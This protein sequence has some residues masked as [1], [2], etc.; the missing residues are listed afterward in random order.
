MRRVALIVAAAALVAA[1]VGASTA[2]ASTF[3]QKGISDDAQ[4]LYGDPDKVFPNL[5]KLHTQVI[6]VNLWW[7]GPNGVARRRPVNACEP[8]RSGLSLGHVRPHGSVRACLQDDAD[9]HRDRDAIVGERLRRLERRADEAV[10]SAG[11]RDRRGEALLGHLQDRRR[12]ADR[13]G[14]EVDRLERAE[15]PGLP[16]AAVRP[17][18]LEVG[19]P[20]REDL[21]DDLQRSRQGREVGQRIEQ[22]RLRGHL[23][24]G[25]QPARHDQVVRLAPCVPA[26]R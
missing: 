9:L 1:L 5:A 3:I 10:G 24:A 12:H 2:G 11:V 7:G 22:G 13:T 20:E 8:G 26:R 19:H 16:E 15:Q 25:Q 23:A 18:G 17:L 6:R 4:I 14:V 21:R